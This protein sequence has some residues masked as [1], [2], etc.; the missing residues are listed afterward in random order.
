[1][2]W[3]ENVSEQL[4]SYFGWWSRAD[5]Q[6]CAAFAVTWEHECV[7]GFFFPSLKHCTPRLR[8]ISFSAPP[9]RPSLIPVYFKTL[10]GSVFLSFSSI[11]CYSKF[12]YGATL[13]LSHGSSHSTW[14]SQVTQPWL[15][16]PS[17]SPWWPLTDLF[18]KHRDLRRQRCRGHSQLA[19]TSLATTPIPG[20]RCDH[21]QTGSGK[22]HQLDRPSSG[23][24]ENDK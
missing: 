1:M 11:T 17:H 6:L 2:W 16:A 14:H 15:L 8:N 19:K 4:L 24:L 22:A 23:P 21:S 18:W 3:A 7:G 9:K 20:C 10:L 12:C 13:A 5:F